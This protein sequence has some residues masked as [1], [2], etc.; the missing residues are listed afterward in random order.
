MLITSTRLARK[1]INI[2]LAPQRSTCLS[3]LKH[4]LKKRMQSPLH[5]LFDWSITGMK[6]PNRDKNRTENAVFSN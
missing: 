5:A 2:S 3:Q 4:N 1:K 6:S